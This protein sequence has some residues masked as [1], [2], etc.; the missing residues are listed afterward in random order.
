[1][2]G[3]TFLHYKMRVIAVL[4]IVLGLIFAFMPAQTAEAHSSLQEMTPAEKV[5]VEKSPPYLKLRFNEPVEQDLAS[6]TIYDWNAKPVFSGKPDS[7]KERSAV[8]KFSLPKLKQG[9]YTVKWDVVS[10]D[11]HPVGGSYTFAVGEATENGIKSVGNTDDSV[12]PLIV[13]RSIVQGLLLIS[14]GLYI[15]SWL[16]ARKKYPGLGKLLKRKYTIFPILFAGTIIELVAYAASLPS[17]L[18]QTILGG[19]WELLEQFPFI[20]MLLAQLLVLVLL[21]IPGMVQSWYI[22]LW[23]ILAAAPAFGGHVWG[24]KHPFLALIPRIIHELSIAIWLGALCYVILLI[25][26]NKKETQDNI[27]WPEF[28]PFFVNKML[29]MAGLVVLSGVSMVYMQ[30]GWTALFTDWLPWNTLLVVKIAL[31]LLMLLLAA[32]QTFKWKSRQV[33]TTNKLVRTEWVIGLI[34]IVFGIWMSQSA[35]PIPVKSYEETLVSHQMKAQV[36]I[37]KLQA[38]DREMTVDIPQS[39]GK[40]AEHVTAE[41][42]MPEHDMGSGQLTL[43]KSG[44]GH[45]HIKLPFTMA[46]TWRI[47]IQATYPDGTQLNW[48]DKLFIMGAK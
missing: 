38:G 36:H 9:S 32:Y 39:G 14:T 24:M 29:V 8:L 26:W 17:G 16:A 37:E 27:S 44:S 20:L 31:T 3:Q 4:S 1:M 19:R 45:Y 10:L 41:I 42:T 46:G 5:V 12:T 21:V 7:G 22:A 25:I 28:R 6:V 11:G 2:T 47:D 30:T 18:I 40:N 23:L 33:F 43:K 48:T 35:Y 34:V 15:F 13:S